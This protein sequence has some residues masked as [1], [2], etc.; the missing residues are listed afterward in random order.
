MSINA[1]L[2]GEDMCLQV[3]VPR[4]FSF[5]MQVTG[6]SAGTIHSKRTNRPYTQP[7]ERIAS[8]RAKQMAKRTRTTYSKRSTILKERKRA[9]YW[10]RSFAI[11]MT[12]TL[13]AIDILK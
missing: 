11:S 3:S 1:E 5:L 4:Q 8:V 2:C 12:R 13:L 6:P 10:K 7:R 9:Q